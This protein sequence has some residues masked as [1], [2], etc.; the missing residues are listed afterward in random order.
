MTDIHPPPSV[1]APGYRALL[2]RHPEQ[3]ER[4]VALSEIHVGRQRELVAELE[5]DGHDT[6][7]H[8]ALLK[9]FEDLRALHIRHRDRIRGELGIPNVH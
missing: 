6:R 3:A 5:R 8:R 1:S 9:Q 4:H 2:K 7:S